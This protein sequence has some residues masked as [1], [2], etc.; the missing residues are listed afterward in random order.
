MS[1]Q[2]LACGA[3]SAENAQFC[4]QCGA[5]IVGQSPEPIPPPP[6]ELPSPPEPIPPPLAAPVSEQAAAPESPAP[7]APDEPQ[8]TSVEQSPAEDQP[9]ASSPATPAVA[10]MSKGR[11]R[12][13]VGLAL[14]L[15]V[16]VAAIFGAVLYMNGVRSARAAAESAVARAETAVADAGMAAEAGNDAAGLVDEG[17]ARLAEAKAKIASG[18]PFLAAPYREA[19]SLAGQASSAAAQVAGNLDD[20]L[21]SADSLRQSGDYQGA[22]KAWTALVTTYPRSRQ[23]ADARQAALDMLTSDVA[24]DSAVAVEDDL[25]LAI[26][27]A[28]MYPKDATPTEL[29]A[30]VH[31]VLL[32]TATSELNTLQELATANTNWAREIVRQG[33]I[34]GGM[35]DAFQ[36]Q[37]YG[38][39]DVE[40]IQRIQG[41]VGKLGQPDQMSRLYA[42]VT[43]ATSLAAA[44]KSVADNPQS[45]TSNS[46]T[47]SAAQIRTVRDN[48]VTMQRDIDEGRALADALSKT[49]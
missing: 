34:T 47:F 48:A 41:M 26:D 22:V 6:Q 39:T 38:S 10:K 14:G 35:V 16:L 1:I 2:C 42:V 12:L 49:L 7:L 20:A 9:P 43:E 32:D 37:D 15:V 30:R 46:E 24:D 17:K 19:Q 45:R 40:W 44:C 23:A 13:L 33:T 4:S 29:T 8:L 36:N 31:T 28:A 11:I 25:Q 3:D 21:A 27:V 5:P 18:S